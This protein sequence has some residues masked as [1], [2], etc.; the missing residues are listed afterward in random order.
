MVNGLRGIGV[1]VVLIGATTC[2]KPFGFYP[3]DN[4]G[5]TF[6]TIQFQGVNDVGFGDYADGF[7]PINSSATNGVRLPG[8]AVGDDFAV[9]LGNPGEAL[10]AAALTYRA[11]GSCPTPSAVAP[12]QSRENAGEVLAI[13]AILP[14]EDPLME[15]NRDMRMPG[16]LGVLPR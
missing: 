6:Y 14:P 15:Q 3:Q 9:E 13:D 8:C 1:E 12:L 7:L 10:L 16:G 5:E 4:C 2:G 11:N